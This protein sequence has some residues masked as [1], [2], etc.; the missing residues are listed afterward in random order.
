MNMNPLRRGLA[1]GLSGCLLL[2]M[3]IVV[4]L[5]TGGLLAAVGDD[6]AAAICRW[7]T[8]PLGVLWVVSIA[9]TTAL[10][11]ALALGRPQRRRRPRERS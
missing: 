8:V 7:C 10:S 2:P 6:A 5:G 1:W 9:A 4:A 11:A 3:V